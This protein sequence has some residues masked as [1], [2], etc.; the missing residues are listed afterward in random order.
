MGIKNSPDIIQQ[1]MQDLLGDLDWVRVYM[2]DIL[3]T[4]SKD[5]ADHMEKLEIVL[6]RLAQAGFRANVRKCFFA[7][8]KL[9]YLGYWVTR[10]GIQPQP[11]KVEAIQRLTPPKTRKQLR[12]FLGMVNYYRDMW[13]RRSHILAPLTALSSKSSVWKWGKEQQEAFDEAKRTICKRSN[14]SVP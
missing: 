13:R 7:E 9:D 8:E 11:K 12:R 2:D 14:L 1:V 6:E 3:I 5:F 4:S 10:K